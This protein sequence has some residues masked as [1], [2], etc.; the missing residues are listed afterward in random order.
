M[1]LFFCLLYHVL[2]FEPVVIF[3]YVTV[4]CHNIYMLS[5]LPVLCSIMDIILQLG[6]TLHKFSVLVGIYTSHDEQWIHNTY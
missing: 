4:K 6:N 5:K 3:C 1:T 2:T